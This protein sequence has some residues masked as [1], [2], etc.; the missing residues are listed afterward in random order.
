M[1]TTAFFTILNYILSLIVGLFPTGNG[2]PQS[3]HDSASLIGGYVGILDPI[4]PIDT[5]YQ[6]ILI[7][8]GIE[9][10][11]FGF[12]TFKW[13]LSHVPFIGGRG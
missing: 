13:L 1:I 8:I 3:V 5:L 12:K 2:F 11:I 6:I 4:F 9:I 7:I 10:A